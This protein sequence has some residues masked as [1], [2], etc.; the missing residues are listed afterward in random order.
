[1]ATKDVVDNQFYEIYSYPY[2][3]E[4]GFDQ[5]HQKQV[6]LRLLQDNRLARL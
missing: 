2:Q 3:L 4:H 5:K 1:M 6:I